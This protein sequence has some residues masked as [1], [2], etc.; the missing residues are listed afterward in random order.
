MIAEGR[1][2]LRSEPQYSSDNEEDDDQIENAYTGVIQDMHKFAAALTS[3][4]ADPVHGIRDD[5][6]VGDD[7]NLE[8]E[9]D[10]I[11]R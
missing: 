4:E 5:E 11:D 7:D 9:L 2:P 3:E 10:D 1:K 6:D 8:E